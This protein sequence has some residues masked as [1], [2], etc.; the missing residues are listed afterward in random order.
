MA[1]VVTPF[2]YELPAA[3]FEQLVRENPDK[4]VVRS[5]PGELT[6]RELD[7]LSDGFANALAAA[8]DPGEPVAFLIDDPL[9]FIPAVVGALKGGR[10]FCVLD[11]THPTPRLREI[12]DDLEPAALVVT[13]GTIDAAR[14]VMATLPVIR[15]ETVE[16]TGEPFTDAD[17]DA[18]TPAFIVYTSGSTGR[19]KGVVR[20]HGTEAA[21]GADIAIEIGMRD[22][23]RSARLY[24]T[25]YAA[26][27]LVMLRTLLTGAT[28][29]V[30]PLAELNLA[31]LADWL[32]QERISVLETIPSLFRSLL[33]SL[34]PGRR[35]SS[36]RLV[37]LSGEAVTQRDLSLF[38]S[39]CDEQ[40]RLT[41]IFASSEASCMLAERFGSTSR[42]EGNAIPAGYPMHGVSVRLVDDDGRDA[43]PGVGG[44]IVVESP[45]VT[46]GYWR[47]PELTATK[48]A[49]GRA[50]GIRVLRTGDRGAI[51]P[52]GRITFLGRVD[53]QLK[54]RGFRVDP[55]EVEMALMSDREILHAAVVGKPDPGGAPRLVAYVVT[56]AGVDFRLVRSRL[57]ER[58]PAHAVPSL[59]FRLDEMPRIATGKIDRKALEGR[60]D[61]VETSAGD[62]EQP[63]DE[64]EEM[65]LETWRAM[66]RVPTAGLDDGFFDLGGDS[67]RAAELFAAIERTHGLAYPLTV[68]IE[69]GTVR[70]LAAVIRGDL[71]RT[72]R[73]AVAPVAP[74]GEIEPAVLEAWRRALV[75]PDLCVGADFFENGGDARACLR[76]RDEIAFALGRRFPLALF[77]GFRTAR[78]MALALATPSSELRVERCVERIRGGSGAPLFCFSGKGSDI[79]NFMPLAGH[80]AA[81]VSVYGVRGFGLEQ[82]WCPP[83]DFEL[84]VELAIDEIRDVQPRGPYRFTGH[85]TG[86]L[87]ALGVA[88][89]FRELGEATELLAMIDTAHP[90]LMLSDT[91]SF[92]DRVDAI[93]RTLRAIRHEPRH[94][95]GDFLRARRVRRAR[96]A[97]GELDH[98][99]QPE[100]WRAV[101]DVYLE[102]VMNT[103]HE[104]W[105]GTVVLFRASSSSV[106][107]GRIGWGE[108][109]PNLEIVPVAGGHVS[110]LQEPHV[111][112]VAREIETRLGGS[113]ER[114]RG[115][116]A[117]NPAK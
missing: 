81:G 82:G 18:D 110:V 35:L 90:S 7:R 105:D 55:T 60:V 107:H 58:L 76:A 70:M 59:F 57:A 23:D 38:Q 41:A 37:T 112:A 86:G 48:I 88:R 8:G 19:P 27:I 106:S 13:R 26:S 95:L 45:Q 44:E 31:E 25:S 114:A 104:R 47:A 53:T 69:A 51:L 79:L 115:G 42:I 10:P 117:V 99:M 36:I 101:G 40:A 30:Y 94:H 1:D 113:P 84:L 98:S 54:I 97:L 108:L 14:A 116:F 11:A 67:L 89:R 17:V 77:I 87:L 32:N 4:S 9:L 75:R 73:A 16:P 111:G 24:S 33:G 109:L 43:G 34:E 68:I 93:W 52:D 85:S 28:I 50:P 21:A 92:G 66:L 3:R 39:C 72:T 96:E 5:A 103:E 20:T 74:A 80:L 6:R 78:E 91:A 2:P 64:I 46:T 56:D 63:S 12:L 62:G 22:S 65:L 71:R 61:P 83:A 100:R 49:P 15:A 102:A 29:C